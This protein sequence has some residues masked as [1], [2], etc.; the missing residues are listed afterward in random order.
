MNDMDFVNDLKANGFTDK[1]ISRLRTIVESVPTKDQT[2]SSIVLDLSKRFWGGV[3]GM[4]LM[5]VI[6]IFGSIYD[7]AENF[8]IYL[9]VILFGVTVVYIVT[10]MKLAWKAHRY[11]AKKK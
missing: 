6:A 5:A 7:S 4:L 2:F 3:I 11:M 1:D 10:P 8:I 9:I